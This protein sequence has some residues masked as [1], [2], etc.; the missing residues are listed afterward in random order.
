MGSLR[1]RPTGRIPRVR[2]GA[3]GSSLG[4]RRER[5]LRG[6]PSGA[7]VSGTAV[8][9]AVPPPSPEVAEARRERE[10]RRLGGP[11]PCS[12]ACSF[13]GFG[14]TTACPSPLGTVFVDR[15]VLDRAVVERVEL[16]CPSGAGSSVS[17]SAVAPLGVR[18]VPPRARLRLGPAASVG[19]SG[20]PVPPSAVEASLCACS[21]AD[22]WLWPCPR[23]RPLPPRRRRRGDFGV[24]LV[25]ASAGDSSA[26]A[27]T[28]SWPSSLPL[29]D[30]IV[31]AGRL[32]RPRPPRDRRRAGRVVV[33]LGP[34]SVAGEISGPS[35]PVEAPGSATGAGAGATA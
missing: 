28:G 35:S 6:S 18:G 26:V 33:E 16:V 12:S 7:T 1:R 3:A 24:S 29:G 31:A 5:R 20:S 4:V 13:A 22:L 15:R 25:A 17:G 21:C 8:A 30:E 23:P 10:R 14:S 32:P 9:V 19:S 27:T 34:P 2:V 11:S